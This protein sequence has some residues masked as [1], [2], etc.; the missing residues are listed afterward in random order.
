VAG[1]ENIVWL[2]FLG[3][4]GFSKS[5][6]RLRAT[7]RHQ[8]LLDHGHQPLRHASETLRHVLMIIPFIYHHKTF[9]NPVITKLISLR[10]SN[11]QLIQGN[12]VTAIHCVG[13][14]GHSHGHERGVLLVLAGC[15]GI[16]S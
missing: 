8:A 10:Q 6:H 3:I 1:K 5:W 12:H 14:R 9:L 2:D 16:G 4:A 13:F 15:I 7:V 11:I